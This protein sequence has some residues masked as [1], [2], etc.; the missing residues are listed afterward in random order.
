MEGRNQGQ[1]RDLQTSQR[2]RKPAELFPPQ[3]HY[4]LIASQS[5]PEPETLTDPLN[6][7]EREIL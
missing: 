2:N 7:P 6:S 4:A 5:E 3:A 1:E